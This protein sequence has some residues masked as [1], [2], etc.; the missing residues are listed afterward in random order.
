MSS[1][2][3]KHGM[4]GKIYPE[5][6]ELRLKKADRFGAAVGGIFAPWLRPRAGRF[7][8]I[9]EAV[10]RCAPEVEKFSDEQILATGRSLAQNLRQEGFR[11]ALVARAFAL[12]REAAVRTVRTCVGRQEGVATFAAQRERDA[13]DAVR[14]VW[15]P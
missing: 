13:S 12:V 6:E 10:N 5:R 15:C 2:T 9:V 7:K 14:A 4:V 3:V 11:Q 1:V 8:W